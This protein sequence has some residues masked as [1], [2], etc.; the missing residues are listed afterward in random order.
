[1]EIISGFPMANKRLTIGN[2]VYISLMAGMASTAAFQY[3]LTTIF[4][5]SKEFWVGLLVFIVL[6]C[7]SGFMLS[8]KKFRS[9]IRV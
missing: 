2:I 5:D 4:D 8:S 7:S 9:I 3:L 6:A 1:M